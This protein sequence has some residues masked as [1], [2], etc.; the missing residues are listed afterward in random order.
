[1]ESYRKCG[2]AFRRNGDSNSNFFTATATVDGI[3]WIHNEGNRSFRFQTPDG[4]IYRVCTGYTEALIPSNVRAQ[5]APVQILLDLG[6]KQLDLRIGAVYTKYGQAPWRQCG[7]DCL[8]GTHVDSYFSR[9]AT[10]TTACCGQ[11]RQER[12]DQA[13][14]LRPRPLAGAAQ[15]HPGG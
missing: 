4:L 11:D 10:E 12:R 13:G 2:C 6:N 8:S 14:Q 15:V 7:M 9:M 5:V 3:V 1:M